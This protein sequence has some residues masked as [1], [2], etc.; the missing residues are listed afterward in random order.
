MYEQN[1]TQGDLFMKEIQPLGSRVPY[2]VDMG[3]HER[4][5]NVRPPV[6]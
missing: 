5:Y 6:Q 3:N 4:A 1:G 2:M